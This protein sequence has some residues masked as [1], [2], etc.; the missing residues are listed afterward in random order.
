MEEKGTGEGGVVFDGVEADGEDVVFQR[1][2]RQGFDFDVVICEALPP[3]GGGAGGF[4]AREVGRV[5]GAGAR[6]VGGVWAGGFRARARG[7][8]GA[9]VGGVGSRGGGVGSRGGGVGSGVGGGGGFGGEGLFPEDVGGGTEESFGEAEPSGVGDGLEDGGAEGFG[10]GFDGIGE[11]GGFGARARREAEDVDM[12]EVHRFDEGLGF[13]ELVVS[14]AGEADDH[15][16][17]DGEIRDRGACFIE[18]RLEGGFAGASSHAFEGGVASGLE[19]EVEV[20]AE[21]RV[22]PEG[23]EGI[24]EIP[25]FE[26]REAQARDGGGVED[27]SDQGF[28]IGGGVFPIA[29]VGAEVDACQD[30]LLVADGDQATDLIEDI[31][32]GSAFFRAASDLGD[33]EGTAVV[34]AVLDLD[35]GAGAELAGSGFTGERFVI[36]GEGIEAEDIVDEVIFAGIGDHAGDTGDL[37]DKIGFDL[38]VASGDDDRGVR[39]RAVGL[40]DQFSRAASGFGGDSAGIDDA[41]IRAFGVGQDLVSKMPE[42]PRHLFDL[43]FVE[44]A[45][46]GFE[47]DFHDSAPMRREGRREGG[48]TFSG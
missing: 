1:A 36:E 4:G 40:V 19:G 41:K 29:S 45:S 26:G 17:A 23:K 12:A 14:F 46:K 42:G 31:G 3:G 25:R 37:T 47:I 34:A 7:V 13:C 15:I 38:A 44:S 16:G 43:A 22:L 20:S 35:E 5:G 21:S 28:E 6:A 33:A 32:E 24:G 11:G 2:K 30:D 8:E 48:F 18:D 10:G 27:G 39:G 9:N